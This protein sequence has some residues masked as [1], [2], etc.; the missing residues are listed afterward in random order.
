MA[1][2]H[3]ALLAPK[4]M[5]KQINPMQAVTQRAQIICGYRAMVDVQMLINKFI[6]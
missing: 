3:G 4:T 1:E 2:H 6:N 5:G